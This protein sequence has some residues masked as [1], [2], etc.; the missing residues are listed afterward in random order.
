MSWQSYL[1]FVILQQK[2]DRVKTEDDRDILS[3]GGPTVM[4][5]GEVNIMS[6]FSTQGDE[7]QVSCFWIVFAT[8]AMVK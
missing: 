5:T 6:T 3:E 8:C 4:E 7:P 1:L 2:V